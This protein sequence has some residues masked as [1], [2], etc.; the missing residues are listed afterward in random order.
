MALQTAFASGVRSRSVKTFLFGDDIFISYSRADGATYAAGLGDALGK[1]GFSCKLDQWGSEPGRELPEGLRQALLRSAMLVVIGTRG[2]VR[3]KHVA[4]EVR[5]FRGTG[6]PIIPLLLGDLVLDDDVSWRNDVEGLPISHEDAETLNTG[7]PSAHVVNRIEKTFTFST[8]ERRLRRSAQVAAG[9]FVVLLAAS[10]ILGTYAS[11]KAAQAAKAAAEAV[12]Q[13]DRA[14]AAAKRAASQEVR[15][16]EARRVADDEKAKAAEASKLAGEAARRATAEG[17]RAAEAS[18]RAASA[19]DQRVIAE[20]GKREAQAQ[21][22]RARTETERQQKI[23]ALRA[24]NNRMAADLSRDP[25]LLERSVLVNME[26]VRSFQELGLPSVEAD[27]GLRGSMQLMPRFV[28]QLPSLNGETALSPDGEYFANGWSWNTVF[29]VEVWHLATGEKVIESHHQESKRV[30]GIAFGS[31]AQRRTRYLATAGDDTF[32]GVWD[33]RQRRK[34]AWLAHAAPVQAVTFDRDSSLLMTAASD[35]TLHLWST[36]DWKKV[37][38]LRPQVVA[39]VLAFGPKGDAFAISDAEGHVQIWRSTN[40]AWSLTGRLR[41]QVGISRLIFSPDGTRLLVVIDNAGTATTALYDSANASAIGQLVQND[42]LMG[43][44][45]V[46]ADSE[47]FYV[48]TRGGVRTLDWKSGK[49]GRLSTLAD[50]AKGFVSADGRY[51]GRIGKSSYFAI[52]EDTR[53]SRPVATIVYPADRFPRGGIFSYVKEVQAAGRH[54]LTLFDDRY[55]IWTNPES[56]PDRQYRHDQRVV[57]ASLVADGKLLG[58]ASAD[59]QLKIWDTQSG[60]ELFSFTTPHEG[61]IEPDIRGFA[62]HPDGD[63]IAVVDWNDLFVVQRSTASVVATMSFFEAYGLAFSPSGRHLAAAGGDGLVLWATKSWQPISIGKKAGYVTHLRFSPNG[64]YIATI[65]SQGERATVWRTTTGE[66]VGEMASHDSG[67]ETVAFSRDEKLLAVSAAGSTRWDAQVGGIRASDPT[68]FVKEVTTGKEVLQVRHGPTAPSAVE[69]TPDGM[70]LV[71]ASGASTLFQPDKVTVKVWRLSDGK[72]FI[73][74]DEPRPVLTISFSSDG[75]LMVTGGHGPT[76]NVRETERW[77]E[78]A[79]LE[80]P[81]ELHFVSLSTGGKYVASRA[82]ERSA[83]VWTLDLSDLL[84]SACERVTR[85][86][87]ADEWRLYFGSR[88][89]RAS[90]P[91]RH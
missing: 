7:V 10:L 54:V 83:Q 60:A 36:S 32:A 66:I 34:V 57:F 61:P 86:L 2:A 49:E 55:A 74:L 64:T 90:C 27:R 28:A 88:P 65:T 29:P 20:A 79:R 12:R 63:L 37:A 50:E 38:E 19:D 13:N 45:S 51:F 81:E 80:S 15:A 22:A 30:N 76:T 72:E 5:T 71:T 46:G 6:R 33:L 21:E 16:N 8:K 78:V 43:D 14:V 62:V 48:A 42:V 56:L 53:T 39:S 69:F 35:Q 31:D 85:E 3:S 40:G 9:V 87:T 44:L 52:L 70:H 89:R 25:T 4:D 17:K 73:S 75:R 23:A 41:A 11:V 24:A 59:G 84:A 68:V 82:T 18:A 1:L 91:E 77:E 26:I 67:A 47:R 58:T